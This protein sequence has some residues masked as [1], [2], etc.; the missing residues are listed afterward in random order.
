[1]CPRLKITKRTYF[2]WKEIFKENGHNFP[3]L[4][5]QVR[6]SHCEIP[7]Q[8][9][10]SDQLFSILS[11]KWMPT[12]DEFWYTI[13]VN[14]HTYNTGKFLYHRPFFMTLSNLMSCRIDCSTFVANRDRL[15]RHAIRQHCPSLEIYIFFLIFA[16]FKASQNI[17]FYWLT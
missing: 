4:L 13:S 10:S 1:M 6:D 15:D 17:S 3:E 16:F 2:S 14:E 9:K 5:Q 8:I 11:L 7:I 12:T